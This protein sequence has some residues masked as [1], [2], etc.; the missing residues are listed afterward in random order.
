LQLGAGFVMVSS[1]RDVVK[2]RM[3][4]LLPYFTLLL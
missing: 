2:V 1:S 4:V 3:Q